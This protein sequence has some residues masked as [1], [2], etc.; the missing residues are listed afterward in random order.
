MIITS[1]LDTDLYKFTMQQMVLHHFCSANVE[2]RFQCRTSGIDLNVIAPQIREQ[3]NNLDGLQLSIQELDYLRSLG[4]LQS[5]FIAFLRSFRLHS[6]Y[7]DVI[8]GENLEIIVRGPW[9]QTILFEVPILA[10]VNELF[11]RHN[12]P[13]T[14]L[15]QGK[16]RLKAKIDKVRMHSDSHDFRF[17]DF[18][19]R[20]RF[21][22]TWQHQ[23]VATCQSELPNNL[24][25][26]SNV[27]LAM[28]FGLVPIGTMA[29]EYIQACQVLGPHLRESQIFAFDTWA[30][31]Y[32]GEL[33]IA[34]SDTYGLTAFLLDFDR[35][36]CLLF[37][38]ARHDSGDPFVW[39]DAIIKHYEAMDIDPKTKQL[40]FSDGLDFELAL[41]LLT[42]F[43]ERTNPSF[44]IGTNLTNDVGISAI[45]IVMKMTECND[46][47]VAKISDAPGKTMCINAT[48]LAYL[49][50]VFRS[51]VAD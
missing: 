31:Q 9:L 13:Q 4:F 41:K 46:Q 35:Y 18:G 38:G 47:P 17:A 33:G 15:L 23:V 1:L 29:H 50:Q 6:N 32:R 26:T 2:Y 42:Y 20:R 19:T 49:R 8:S 51:N 12:Y 10:I 36:F 14:D 24:T 3:I 37:A 30:R 40:V 44:G 7:V 39:G 48:Y 27:A 22:K 43:K 21:S 28:E 5:D 16:Q 11:Y 45:Q 34:L 25:G